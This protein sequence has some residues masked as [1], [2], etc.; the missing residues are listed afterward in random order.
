[1]NEIAWYID[2]VAATL[3]ALLALGVVVLISFDFV[4]VRIV[5]GS[6]TERRRS[7]ELDRMH[8][9][10]GRRLVVERLCPVCDREVE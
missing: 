3:L 5:E 9:D 2:P 1:M 8:C 7:V 10:C 4:Q 6:R